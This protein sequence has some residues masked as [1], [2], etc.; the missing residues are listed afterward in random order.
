[1]S[2]PEKLPPEKQR[3]ATQTGV[4]ALLN[5][6]LSDAIDLQGQIKQAHWN[7]RGLGFIGIHRLFDEIAAQAGEWADMFAER[8]ASLGA[9]AEGTIAVAAKRSRLVPYMLGI[10]SCEAHISGVGAT[11]AMFADSVRASIDA[12]DAQGDAV[13]TDLFT[14]VARA[15]DQQRYLVMS[16][17]SV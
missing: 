17:H 6:H 7:V 1:M 12:S 14:E 15:A 10:A 11:L 4:A 2:K 16:H 8:A 5:Q 9:Q 13:T 3:K